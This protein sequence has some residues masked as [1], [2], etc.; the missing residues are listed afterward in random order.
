MSS[1]A[2]EEIKN[3]E[4]FI[5]NLADEIIQESK[6]N[7]HSVNE[8]STAVKVDFNPTFIPNKAK[9]TQTYAIDVFVRIRPLVG[10]EIEQKH[11]CIE[12]NTK[13]DKKNDKQSL[14]LKNSSGRNKNSTYKGLKFIFKPEH[15]NI[16]T[17]NK[18]LL[19]YIDNMFN[20]LSMCIF[21]YGHTG[22]GK[23]HTIFGNKTND[24]LYLQFARILCDKANK[25]KDK[26]LLIEIRFLELYQGKIYDLLSNDKVVCEIREDKDGNFN[27]RAPMVK[28]ENGMFI[29]KAVGSVRIKNPEINKITEAIK[30]GIQSR[31]VGISTLHDESS[32]SHAFLEFEL[33][34][35]QL[36]KAREA[37][38]KLDAELTV[39]KLDKDKAGNVTIVD[40][41]KKSSLNVKR[42]EQQLKDAKKLVKKLQNDKKRKWVGGSFVFVDLAG[43]E[44]GSDVKKTETNIEMQERNEINSSLLALKE[45]I[46]A[47]NLKKSHVPYR[48][49]KLTMYL[50][51]FLQGKKCKGIMISNMSS[52]YNHIK[53]SVN[54]MRYTQSIA[55]TTTIKNKK[56]TKAKKGKQ[57][58]NK[59][60]DNNN[61]NENTTD[62]AD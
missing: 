16:F 36:V 2:T 24:G 60:N 59:T 50:R 51:K 32:R 29:A 21:A 34:T 56:A 55:N 57:K 42:L 19:P 8:V 15:D 54:T 6:T 41:K 25:I 52:S 27:L 1:Q 39:A 13:S 61:Q 33:V 48:Q 7:G 14:I 46:R 3:D 45:V 49:H 31:N 53:K 4:T 18:C 11:Q 10:D 58:V 37:V 44:F 62:N 28:D 23:T 35:D 9:K 17:F 47:K 26:N 40:N 12:F 38:P 20:G 5:D 22:S 43:N 30:N